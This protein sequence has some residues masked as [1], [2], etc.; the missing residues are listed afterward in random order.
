MTFAAFM[1]DFVRVRDEATGAL[2]PP[3]LHLEE[4]RL[5]AALD[6]IDPATGLRQFLTVIISW[7]RKG[8]K[9][10]MSACIGIYLLVFDAFHTH[11][12]VI[13]QASTKDQ[14]QS[15]CFKAMKRLVLANAWLRVRISILADSMLYVDEAGVEHSLRVLPHSPGGVHGLNGSCVIYDEAWVHPNWDALE[16]TSPSPARRCPVTV[17]ASYSGLKSQRTPDNPWFSVLSSALRGEDP[18]V[19]LSHISGREGALSIPWITPGWLARLEQQFAHVR[20]KFLRLAYN[21]WSTSDVGAF[22]TEDEISDALDRTLPI[23]ATIGPRHPT[24]RIGVDLGLVKDRTAIVATNL[25]TSG[26]LVVRHVEI[27]QGTRARPVSLIDVEDRIARVAVTLGTRDVSLDRWQSAQ[28]GEGLRR[29]GL[30]VRAVTCDAAW[31]DRAATHLKHWFSQ[32]H[33]QIPAHAGLLEELEGLEAEELRRRDRVRFTASGS[34]HDDAC[35][36]LC[37]SAERFAGGIRPD[38]SVV[39]R[40]KLPEID[41]CVA[42]HVL[43]VDYCDCPVV[44][45][46]SA[47]PGCRR[48]GMFMHAA[49]MHEAHIKTHEWVPLSVFVASR[50]QPN[51]WLR[52]R[53]FHQMCA[54]L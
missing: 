31:L 48:C 26:R 46:P 41:L 15:A 8:G 6:A 14:G 32:R 12:E 28:M 3:V 29:R 44:D 19:F 9:T 40:D 16:G 47:H 33:I 24:A 45:G 51:A 21:V 4:E 7:V 10:W 30:S 20:S 38:T 42:E 49:T 43:G 17:W 52:A 25:D 35:V 53:R 18:T 39:G 11:R 50:L 5:V 13:V 27:I 22:L 34:N 54:E 1:A 2:R 23:T 37:L 36:A